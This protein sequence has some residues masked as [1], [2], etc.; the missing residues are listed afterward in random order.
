MKENTLANYGTPFNFFLCLR[1]FNTMFSAPD[2]A[3]FVSTQRS[4]N[5]NIINK[6][7]QRQLENILTGK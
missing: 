4:S 6:P 3:Q 1:L 7:G 2:F 5:H